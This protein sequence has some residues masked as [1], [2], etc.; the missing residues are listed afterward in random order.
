[1]HFEEWLADNGLPY[2]IVDADSDISQVA[3]MIFTGG[4]DLGDNHERDTREH[5]LFCRCREQHIPMLGICR[6]MQ[7]VAHW[8][9]AE[10]VQDLGELNSVHR[11]TEEGESR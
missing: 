2:V 7:V 3:A 9:G 8:M 5:T 10:L 4:P 1:M 6:G 11:A